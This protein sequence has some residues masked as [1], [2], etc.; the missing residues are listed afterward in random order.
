MRRCS[1]CRWATLHDGG[2][3]CLPSDEFVNPDLSCRYWEEGPDIIKILK[4]WRRA[5][6]YLQHKIQLSKEEDNNGTDTGKS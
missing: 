1:N 3:Y 5:R 6:E 4:N 2:F